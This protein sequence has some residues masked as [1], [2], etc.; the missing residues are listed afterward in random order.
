MHIE[1]WWGRPFGTWID[2]LSL[3]ASIMIM[4][5]IALPLIL[6][7]LKSNTMTAI[8]VIPLRYIHNIIIFELLDSVGGFL[9]QQTF[10]IKC[11][12]LFKQFTLL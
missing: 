2:A 4:M 5:P 12:A 1:V 7:F 8:F 10:Q 9:F 3:S 6:Y 11:I